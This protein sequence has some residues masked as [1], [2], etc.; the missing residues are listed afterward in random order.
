MR[1]KLN[2]FSKVGTRL[3][4]RRAYFT[5]H[6]EPRGW[7]WL[8]THGQHFTS[9]IRRTSRL[10]SNGCSML[11]IPSNKCLASLGHRILNQELVN[12]CTKLAKKH[13]THVSHMLA[14]S[15]CVRIL[16]VL[17]QYR[18]H[19]TQSSETY[20]I[21]DSVCD[22]TN[23]HN[24]LGCHRKFKYS[25]YFR[26]AFLSVIFHLNLLFCSI[27]ILLMIFCCC[28]CHSYGFTKISLGQICV[29]LSTFK[30]KF[31]REIK[32]PRLWQII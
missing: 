31:I 3:C 13:V 26:E 32:G 2:H 10:F 25:C 30:V 1:L 27:F 19:N 16:Y 23:T 8:Y 6:S 4:W 20:D 11:I 24:R 22:Q 5:C 9:A 14:M 15:E 17:N 18:Y 28:C 12:I 29:Y 7:M 21:V